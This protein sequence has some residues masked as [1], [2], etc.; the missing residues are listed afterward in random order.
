[1]GLTINH[2]NI[3]SGTGRA[4][5][6]LQTQIILSIYRLKYRA[7]YNSTSGNENDECEPDV[8]IKLNRSGASAVDWAICMFCQSGK[9]DDTGG[10]ELTNICTYAI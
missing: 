6:N 8:K 9:P 10:Y 3:H 4:I 2:E 5:G 1:M 7:A